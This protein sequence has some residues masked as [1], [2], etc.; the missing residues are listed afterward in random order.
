ML[1]MSPKR[2]RLFNTLITASLI[3]SVAAGCTPSA[4]Q[5]ATESTPT[6]AV[7][8]TITVAPPP[9]LVNPPAGCRF[10]PRCAKAIAGLCEVQEPGEFTVAPGHTVKCW[11]FK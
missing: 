11:L 1:V 8:P 2:T 9:S 10:H 5:S 6:E 4:T 7:I 3:I